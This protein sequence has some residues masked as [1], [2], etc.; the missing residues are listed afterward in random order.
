MNCRLSVVIPILFGRRKCYTHR[1]L[2]D[3]TRRK[4]NAPL[5]NKEAGRAKDPFLA[6]G[7]EEGTRTPTGLRLL[8]PEPSASTNSATSA[9]CYII[10]KRPLMSRGDDAHFSIH[11]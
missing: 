6:D 10:E 8:D 11:R 3:R 9:F 2:L 4:R 5:P 1:Q 7:A